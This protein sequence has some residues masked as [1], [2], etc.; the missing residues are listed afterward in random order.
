M[1]PLVLT[2]SHFG[3]ARFLSKEEE[4]PIWSRDVGP[5]LA[6]PSKL[7]AHCL[8]SELVLEGT[9]RRGGVVGPV[10]PGAASETILYP[11]GLS[12]NRE[13]LD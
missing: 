6:R 10:T 7:T 3:Q 9:Q 8:H 1:V 12:Q 4:P 11:T 2:H 13:L 5:T